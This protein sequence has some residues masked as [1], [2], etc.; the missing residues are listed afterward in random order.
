MKESWA[1]LL[2]TLVVLS[3]LVV[4]CTKNDVTGLGDELAPA[5]VTSEQTARIELAKSDDF[6]QNDEITITDL[7]VQP[8]DYGT[9][10]KVSANVTPL[11]WGRFV[12]SVVRTALDTVY[13]GDTIAVVHV[14][15]EISG[16]LRIRAMNGVGDTVTI[17]KPFVDNADRKVLFKRVD[18]N[19]KRYW[20]N[21][22]PVASSLVKGGTSDEKIAIKE[23]KLKTPSDSVTIVDPLTYFLRYRWLRWYNRGENAV[24]ELRGGD[25][26]TVRVTL[27][28]ASPDTD[29]VVLRCGATQFQRKRIRMQLVS[30]QVL[31]NGRYQ[32]QFECSWFVHFH[33]GYFHAAVDAMTRETLFDDAGPYAVSWWGVPYRVF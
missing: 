8:T 33:T 25:P 31:P 30:E 9:V 20:L 11:R 2:G 15:K 19:T 7:D 21:W 26:V 10:G 18:R 12:T 13:A 14:H 27:E 5:N 32:R 1:A 29:V 6:V 23:L 17:E 3:L 24:P 28:S 16:L 22:L 4:G